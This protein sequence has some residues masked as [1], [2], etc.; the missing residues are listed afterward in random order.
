MLVVS[1]AS[2]SGKYGEIHVEAVVPY[3]ADSVTANHSQFIFGALGIDLNL[4][5][6][7]TL[8]QPRRGLPIECL[9]GDVLPFLYQS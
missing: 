1:V 3:V 8:Q 4:S 5:S 2:S 7:A 9:V 6:A